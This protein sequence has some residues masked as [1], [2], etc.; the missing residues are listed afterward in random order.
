MHAGLEAELRRTTGSEIHAQG[1]RALQGRAIAGLPLRNHRHPEPGNAVAAHRVAAAHQPPSEQ[2]GMAEA[3]VDQLG[4][5]DRPL[6]RVER[7]GAGPFAGLQ[8][9]RV[10]VEITADNHEHG[11]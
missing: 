11:A 6:P 4:I 2:V 3:E 1:Q 10:A 7:A 9:H 8:Q 5:G